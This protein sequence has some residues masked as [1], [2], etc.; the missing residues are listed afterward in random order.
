MGVDADF[1]GHDSG[2]PRHFGGVGEHVLTVTRSVF[3]LAHQ[4]DDLRVQIVQPELERD[5]PALFP[6]FLFGFVLDLLDDL[7]DPGRMDAAVDDQPLDGLLRDLA[8]I[9][10]ETRQ[11]DRAGRVVDDEIHAGGEL[12]RADVPALA[13]DDPS[14]QIVARQIHDR[15]G[16][17]DGVLG[18]AP[19]DGFGDVVFGAI[20]GRLT[21]L[22]IEPLQQIGGVVTRFALH[23]LDEEIPGFLRREPGNAFELALLRGDQLLVPGGGGRR[24][25]LAFAQR[26]VAR[27][28]LFFEP[29]DGRLS[30]AEHRFA[31][32]EGLFERGRLLAFLARLPI[33]FH[34][35]VVGLLFRLERRL[36]LHRL[37]VAFSLLDDA[38]RLLFR[39][40]DRFRGNPLAVRHPRDE[41]SGTRHDGNDEVD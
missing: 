38:K 40:A 3:Q 13:S 23:L 39:A 7:F 11:D 16:G 10:I 14:L 15:Y 25:F 34:Q 28:Q 30:F 35:D 21:C 17:L 4:P 36:F 5:S 6:D 24:G 32:R 8:P 22:G 27:V 20:D 1:S 2:Q 12:Q 18:R 26:P 37:G 29:L 19:L 41:H 33:R 31:A 9:R